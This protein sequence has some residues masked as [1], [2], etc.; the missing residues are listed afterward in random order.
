MNKKVGWAGR[1]ANE[2]ILFFFIVGMN[3]VC[4]IDVLSKL[5]YSPSMTL[6]TLR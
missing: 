5:C 3:E 2:N 6:V 4:L 1:T